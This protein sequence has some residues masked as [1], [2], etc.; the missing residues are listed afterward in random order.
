MA[1]SVEFIPHTL[2]QCTEF[3]S[4]QKEKARPGMNQ[5]KFVGT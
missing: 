4:L 5:E 2:E 1:S 3:I